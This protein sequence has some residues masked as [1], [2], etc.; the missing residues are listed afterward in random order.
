MPEPDVE[1][2]KPKIIV[3]YKLTEQLAET[4]AERAAELKKDTGFKV[5]PAHVIEAAAVHFL[6]CTPVQ[7]TRMLTKA[8]FAGTRSRR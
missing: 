7:Q 8:G 3:S 4:V 5:W 1:P 6:G 2:T